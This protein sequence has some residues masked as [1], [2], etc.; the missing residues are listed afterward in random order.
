MREHKKIHPQENADIQRYI[1]GFYEAKEGQLF[2]LSHVQGAE[3]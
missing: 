3:A 1:S 2:K